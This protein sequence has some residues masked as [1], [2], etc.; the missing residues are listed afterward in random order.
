MGVYDR[1]CTS[2]ILLKDLKVAGKD[3]NCIN[4]LLQLH[5]YEH[6]FTADIE[7]LTVRVL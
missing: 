3:Y 5:L 6:F 1:P 7:E 2:V 4:I